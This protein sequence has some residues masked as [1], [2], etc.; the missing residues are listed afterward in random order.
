MRYTEGGSILRVTRWTNPGNAG[1]KSQS[2]VA[3]PVLLVIA[4]AALLSLCSIFVFVTLDA[5][6]DVEREVAL[7]AANL[8]SAVAHDVDRNIELLD[9]SLRSA[10]ESWED[11]MVRSLSPGLR[12]KVMFDRS[13]DA[14][15]TGL[16]LILDAD[17]VVQANSK[18]INPKPDV[19]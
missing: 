17:G 10:V 12:Q 14:D 2:R 1:R 4:C 19:F 15:G 18:T 16:M 6:H 5:R 11:P 9:L 7:S 3:R 8:T 13:A